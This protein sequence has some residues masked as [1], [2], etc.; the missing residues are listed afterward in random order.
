VGYGKI[1]GIQNTA[2]IMSDRN[3]P[4]TEKPRRAI[5]SFV[6]REGRATPGQKQAMED[7]WPKY[8]FSSNIPGDDTPDDTKLFG[9]QAPLV[10][11]IGFGDGEAL[12]DA[13]LN[14]PQRNYIGAEVYTPGVG[15][16]LMRIEQEQLENVRLV[17][18]DAVELLK[19]KFADHSLDEIRLFF[20]DP[21][22]KKKHHKRR[23][24]S[25]DFALLISRKLVPGGRLHFATDW[26]PYAE[27]TME[28]LEACPTLENIAGQ[29]IYLKRPD[30]R[31]ETKFEQRGERLGQ[32]SQDL[33]FQTPR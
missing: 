32:Y 25:P 29:G 9:R 20:P 31:L 33:I 21:W 28:I 5:K 24:V 1:R 22:P 17:Q 6:R 15:H 10:L 7:L 2:F 30:N 12:V 19:Q 27:W 18:E 3:I 4:A 26:A 16:C 11:E 13:A 14:D 8:G 23:I